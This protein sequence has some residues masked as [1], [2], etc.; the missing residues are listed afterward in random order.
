LSHEQQAIV[1]DRLVDERLNEVEVRCD[2]RSHL[3]H[4]YV[5]VRLDRWG[6]WA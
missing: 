3:R 2:D 6:P 5:R 4:R 1:I